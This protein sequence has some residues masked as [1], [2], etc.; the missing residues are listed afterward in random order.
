MFYV[1]VRTSTIRLHAGAIKR[2]T[3]THLPE[4]VLSYITNI[5]FGKR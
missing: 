5:Y 3:E 1:S 2:A 4:N